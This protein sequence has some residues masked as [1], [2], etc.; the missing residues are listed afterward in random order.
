MAK[1]DVNPL[2]NHNSTTPDF[3]D[4]FPPVDLVVEAG[5]VPRLIELLARHDMPNLQL[6][7]AWAITNIACTEVRHAHLLIRNGMSCSIYC[8]YRS[9]SAVRI[10]IKTSRILHFSHYNFGFFFTVVNSLEK[11]KQFGVKYKKNRL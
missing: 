10:I 5:I 2:I 6:E 1:S 3:T 7:A 8:F 9:E 4:K 11:I